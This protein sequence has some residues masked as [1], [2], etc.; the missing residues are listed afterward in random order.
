MK[1]QTILCPGLPEL[2]ELN[3]IRG[4]SVAQVCIHIFE[5][6]GGGAEGCAGGCRMQ[7][8]TR[9]IRTKT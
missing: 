1:C 9:S 7:G 6:E 8:E 4:E 3:E 2:V 5:G